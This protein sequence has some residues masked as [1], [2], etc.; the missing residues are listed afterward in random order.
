MRTYSKAVGVLAAEFDVHVLAPDPFAL[1]G[2]GVGDGDVDL[3]DR[4]LD[5]PDLDAAGHDLIVVELVDDVLVGADARGQDLGDVGVGDDRE[6]HVDRPGAGGVL[7][8]VDLAEGE[9][10][11]EHPVL[12]VF[13]ALSRLARLQAAEGHRGADRPVQREDAA[14]RVPA[15]GDD[16]GIPPHLDLFLGELVDDAPAVR[17]GA[18]K[19]HDAPLL[20]VA[21][22]LDRGLVVRRGAEDGR[23]PGHPA[24]DELNAERP[25][26]RVGEKSVAPGL[27]LFV[28]QVAEA[29]DD[30]LGEERRDPG[31]ERRPE[32][33]KPQLLGRFL[34][35]K[36]PYM[37]KDR[38]EIFQRLDLQ[39]HQGVCHRQI[40]GGVR[41]AD[42]DPL[43]FIVP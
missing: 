3:G 38:L 35:E 16:V 34:R 19:H 24:V 26:D 1:E 29:A 36:A 32:V 20:E 15:V 28:V 37:G 23:K 43:A 25:Q 5:P 21:D 33:G 12:A 18:G 27:G 10:E 31:V 8:V 22:D 13:E 41:E 30:L 9:P 39:T 14:D 6:A 2:G 42:L 7:E 40:I 17:G 11:G 4:H